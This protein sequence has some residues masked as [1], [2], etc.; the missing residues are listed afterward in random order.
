[1]KNRIKELLKEKGITQKE[2]AEELGI[3]KDN[4]SHQLTRNNFRVKELEK[5]ANILGYDLIIEFR[6]RKL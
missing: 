2:L 4:L 5:I 6:D 1:M 3:T